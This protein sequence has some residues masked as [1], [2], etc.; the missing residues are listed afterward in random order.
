L[1]HFH[2]IARLDLPAAFFL[3]R[4]LTGN[5]R[6]APIAGLALV[7]IDDILRLGEASRLQAF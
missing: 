3:R 4:P 7:S 1:S 6:A 2:F 5:G